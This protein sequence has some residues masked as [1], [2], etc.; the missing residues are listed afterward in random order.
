M[1]FSIKQHHL[2]SRHCR[3]QLYTYYITLHIFILI[4]IIFYV[5][6]ILWKLVTAVCLMLAVRA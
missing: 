6:Y 2:Q 4:Y 5:T 3:C 1:R